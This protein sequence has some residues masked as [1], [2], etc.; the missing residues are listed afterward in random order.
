MEAG[1]IV[2]LQ[3]DELVSFDPTDP[4][5]NLIE[6][7]QAAFGPTGLGILAVHGVPGFT[8]KRQ[9]LLPLS[10]KLPHLSD[11]GTCVDERSSY[12]V[13]WSHGR[14][15]LAPGKPDLA[16][17]SFYANPLT[18]NL[19]RSL[20]SR[21]GVLSEHFW[22]GQGEAH[23]EFYASNVWPSSLP[24]LQTMF[25]EIGHIVAL[26][27]RLVAVVCDAYCRKNG[28]DTNFSTLLTESLNAKGRLLHYFEASQEDCDETMWCGWH[29]DH[30][31]GPKVKS[32]S[33]LIFKRSEQTCS[34]TI[35]RSRISQVFAAGTGI[36]HWTCPCYVLE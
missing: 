31:S 36:P 5:Q 20:V 2:T 18:E 32:K 1:L 17:G 15:K 25:C 7:I 28:V 29:N 19:V 9:Q 11:I 14:E 34:R 35:F 24:E 21:D 27:G 13:G 30:V 8:E 33:R 6:S 4:N 23:P 12:S 3:Y 26:T 16:K 22:R 10:A